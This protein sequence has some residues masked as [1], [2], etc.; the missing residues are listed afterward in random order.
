MKVLLM[1]M[2]LSLLFP[3]FQSFRSTTIWERLLCYTSVSTRAAV[4]L[5]ILSQFRDD[6]MVGLVAA[7]VLSLGNSGLLLLANLLRG[8]ESECD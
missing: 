7:V 1:L 4:A 6:A 2:L 3:I 5:I 8:L